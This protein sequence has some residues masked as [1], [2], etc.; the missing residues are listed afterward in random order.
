MATIDLPNGTIH[1]EVDG[2]AGASGP[3]VVFVHGFLV[4]GQLW[5]GVARQL[6]AKGI[7]SYRPDLPLGSHREA[8]HADADMSPRGVA[9]TVIS[10]LEAL[11][12]RDVTLVGN[13]TGGAICQFVL[14]T[15]PSRIGRLVL[16][17]CDCFDQFPPAPFDRMFRLSRR[18]GFVR[19]GMQ[20]MRLKALRHSSQ[21]FGALSAK[22]FDPALT[23]AWVDPALTNGGV[24]R[25]IAR[26]CR[27]V[28]PQELLAIADRLAAF[29]GPVLLV[30]GNADP[31]FTIELA[32]KLKDK[33]ADAKLVEVE[34]G[35]T[36][37]ALDDPTRVADEIATFVDERSAV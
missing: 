33:F 37:H 36:F 35:K 25:D 1:Y 32:R 3:P 5:T 18:E 29:A 16:T 20:P 23:R 8:M 34:G 4:D 6:A 24:R 11:D 19:F 2:P 7:R 14:D 17:N 15:D 9:R 26:F 12:L 31:F 28:D 13:D 22:G 10:F 21:G 30:W 27:E